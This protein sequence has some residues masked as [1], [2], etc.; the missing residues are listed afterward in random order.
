[1]EVSDIEKYRES[2]VPEKEV[3]KERE[4]NM[5]KEAEYL[6]AQHIFI[7]KKCFEIKKA[8][9]KYFKRTVIMNVWWSFFDYRT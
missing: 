6:N 8:R 7:L 1:M 3:L 5:A 2:N 4:I 9:W